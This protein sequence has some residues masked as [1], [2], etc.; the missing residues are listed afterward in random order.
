MGDKKELA[1]LLD[2]LGFLT[3]PAQT[4]APYYEWILRVTSGKTKRANSVYSGGKIPPNSNWLL[5]IET[6]Y[7]Q[8]KMEPCFYI[9][10]SS[11]E[12]LDATLEHH[13]YNLIYPCYVMAA[14]L[15]DLHVKPIEDTDFQ[16]AF[17]SEADY[18]WISNFIHLENFTLDRMNEYQSIFS[19]MRVKQFISVLENG[20]L[21]GLG[22]VV[23]ENGWACLSNIIVH[24]N[25]RRKGVGLQLIRSLS[26]WAQQNGAHSIFLQV[27]KDNVRAINLYQKVGFTV[28][29]EH[30]YR[31]KELMVS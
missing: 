24:E 2:Q 28:I 20:E 6:Y 29:S 1:F 31:F 10:Q 4:Q 5:E 3:W 22:T 19:N 9:C 11:P 30:H 14:A 21:V 17:T 7:I 23:I 26:E 12:E 16:F 13:G 8:K 18:H 27:M 25:H 15:S